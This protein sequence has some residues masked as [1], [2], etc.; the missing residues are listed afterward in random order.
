MKACSACDAEM[1]SEDQFCPQCGNRVSSEPYEDSPVTQGRM[2]LADVRYK[3][4]MVYYK[5]REYARAVEAWEQ[6]P[7]DQS[8]HPDLPRLIE[9][10]RSRANG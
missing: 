7:G 2:D 3:L 6:V 4:G 10:A 8:K 1:M 9:E 5:K